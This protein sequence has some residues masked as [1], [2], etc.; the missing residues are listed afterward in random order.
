MGLDPS[1]EAKHHEGETSTLACVEEDDKDS[2][3]IPPNNEAIDI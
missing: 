1:Q 3:D 2:L